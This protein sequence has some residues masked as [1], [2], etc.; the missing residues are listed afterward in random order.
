MVGESM[1]DIE[2]AQAVRIDPPSELMEAFSAAIKAAGSY[3]EVGFVINGDEGS[4]SCIDERGKRHFY[5]F[6]DDEWYAGVRVSEH[7]R[8]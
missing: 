8:D 3:K 7:N 4:I 1:I 5:A 2:T 6:I